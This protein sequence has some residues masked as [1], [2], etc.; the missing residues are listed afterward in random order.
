M[1]APVVWW[2]ERDTRPARRWQLW[3]DAPVF[4]SDKVTGGGR[5][6]IREIRDGYPERTVSLHLGVKW[7]DG[8][9]TDGGRERAAWV[10]E[11]FSYCSFRASRTHTHRYTLSLIDEAQ[12]NPLVIW[13]VLEDGGGA[14]WFAAFT[15]RLWHKSGVLVHITNQRSARGWRR[16]QLL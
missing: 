1:Y 16:L 4:Q 13:E 10:K 6:G 2:N 15:P 9:E 11:I 8:A 5:G 7:G 12:S 3:Q 14:T